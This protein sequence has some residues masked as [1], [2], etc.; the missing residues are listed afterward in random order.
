MNKKGKKM[1]KDDE[2][3]K[4]NKKAYVRFKGYRRVDQER[5]I[6]IVKGDRVIETDRTDRS[7]RKIVF[8]ERKVKA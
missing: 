1:S 5:I 7:G 6:E 2:E 8:G 3:I 4:E